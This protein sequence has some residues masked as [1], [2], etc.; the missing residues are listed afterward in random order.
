M[1]CKFSLSP[2]NNRHCISL[3]GKTKTW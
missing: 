2:Q 1:A 3:P